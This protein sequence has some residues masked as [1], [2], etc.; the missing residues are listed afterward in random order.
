MGTKVGNN[1]G[2]FLR[3][4]ALLLLFPVIS[5]PTPGWWGFY[6]HSQ[7]MCFGQDVPCQ[8]RFILFGRIPEVGFAARTWAASWM[9]NS[10]NWGM[11]NSEIS[12]SLRS[13]AV[14]LSDGLGLKSD[15]VIRI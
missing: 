13:L 1:P 12:S 7:Q 3:A 11:P 14:S 8:L 2:I 15:M 6:V 9:G 10:L 4:P 5:L